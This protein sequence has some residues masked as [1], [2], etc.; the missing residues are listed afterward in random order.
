M[1][2]LGRKPLV[3]NPFPNPEESKEASEK[4]A[5]DSDS[6]DSEIEDDFTPDPAEI[7]GKLFYN[8][9]T[10]EAFGSFDEHFKRV[11]ECKS[12]LWTCELTMTPKLTYP[13]ALESERKAMECLKSIPISLK[14][15]MLFAVAQ[16]KRQ[17]LVDL[18]EDIYNFVKDRYFVGEEVEALVNGQWSNCSILNVV[19]PTE[20]ELSKKRNLINNVD[21]DSHEA[22]PPA[23]V[24]K[25]HV[26]E[27][28]EDDGNSKRKSKSKSPKNVILNADKIRRPR[29]IFTRFKNKLYVKLVTT[30]TSEKNLVLKEAALAKHGVRDGNFVDVFCQP[31]PVF[32][33]GISEKMQAEDL[34]S[35]CPSAEGKKNLMSNFEGSGD[36]RKFMAIAKLKEVKK[37]PKSSPKKETAE[38]KRKRLEREAEERLEAE[39]KRKE[40]EKLRKKEEKRLYAELL[41]DWHKPKEDL[42]LEDLKDL[43]VS[44]PVISRLPNKLFGGVMEILEFFNVFNKTL[45]FGRW[46]P[47]GLT[48]EKVEDAL[49]EE[50]MRAGLSELLIALLELIFQLQDD[51]DS[52]MGS[53]HLKADASLRELLVVDDV[54]NPMAKAVELA[55]VSASWCKQYLGVTLEDL[56]RDCC[57]IS[58]VLR[59]HLL[60]SGAQCSEKSKAWRYQQRGGYSS[61]DDPG[62]QFRLEHGDIL[63]KLSSSHVYQLSPEEKLSV[64]S[65]LIS[66]IMTYV[67]FRDA[68]DETSD[69]IISK[70]RE[71]YKIR[72]DDKKKAKEEAAQRIKEKKEAKKEGK[73]VC[74]TK[75][76]EEE[77]ENP[78]RLET[79]R[80]TEES[81]KKENSERREK[82]LIAALTVLQSQY[83]LLPMGRDRAHRNFW[84]FNSVPGIFVEDHGELIGPCQ[85][86][87]TPFPIKGLPE[88]GVKEKREDIR[89][90]LTLHKAASEVNGRISETG[91]DKENDEDLERERNIVRKPNS[92]GDVLGQSNNSAY[93]KAVVKLEACAE[94]ESKLL[95]VHAALEKSRVF[96]MCLGKSREADCPVH[97]STIERTRWSFY[98]TPEEVEALIEGLNPRG[99]REKELKEVLIAE[100]KRHMARLDRFPLHLLDITADKPGQSA[101]IEQRQKSERRKG[102]TGVFLSYATH[103][104][105]TSSEYM[106]ELTF[107]DKLLEVEEK[108]H[109]GNLGLLK[110]G[111]RDAWRDA[112]MSG[113]YDQQCAK[114][115]WAGGQFKETEVAATPR[116]PGKEESLN[117]EEVEQKE[118]RLKTRQLAAA[119]LQLE[120]S[121]EPKY[122]QPPLGESAA[123][124]SKKAGNEAENHEDEEET[125][126][127]D[128]K[129]ETKLTLLQRWELSLKNVVSVPQL[130]LHLEVLSTSIMWSR[131]TLNARCKVCR[132][133]GDEQLLL[134]C[135]GCNIGY[136]TTCLKPKLKSIPRG[137]WFCPLCKPVQPEAP[138]AR[139]P[140]RRRAF[141]E[142]SDSEIE[143]SEEDEEEENEEM[144]VEAE[145]ETSKDDDEDEGEEAV[146]A[147]EDERIDSEEDVESD[148]E[149]DTCEVCGD[150]GKLIACSG[151]KCDVQ[152]HQK[153][154]DPPVKKGQQGKWTCAKCT[155]SAKISIG[156]KSADKSFEM[157]KRDSR[158]GVKRSRS[159][160]STP[161][162]SPKRVT[163]PKRANVHQSSDS[164]FDEDEDDF[165]PARRSSSGTATRRSDHK[166]RED[167][168]LDVAM[169]SNLL[170]ELVQAEDSWPF[171][172]PVTKKDAP[173]YADKIKNPMDFGTLKGKLINNRYK[174][175][176]EFL[177]DVQLIFENCKDYNEETESVYKCAERMVKLFHKKLDKIG[178][179]YFYSDGPVVRK[180]GKSK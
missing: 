92:A 129:T 20:A 26:Q 81:R 48:F 131:S 14:R 84:T 89:K 33:H 82:D 87:P 117:P 111:E 132:R 155:K 16:T 158:R 126:D 139:R 56:T 161:E 74:Q 136:H 3:R 173:D 11:V 147:E 168:D 67:G 32:H 77:E 70:R 63:Q 140:P 51:E 69:S 130:F 118:R 88:P 7:D 31:M 144:T 114:L 71:L 175:N 45:N 22:W 73:P 135:D 93:A 47:S 134:L 101:R 85:N 9:M 83:A 171:L 165:A 1:P 52:E 96:G 151:K 157:A 102:S 8:S 105:G 80:Q 15:G 59:L 44:K 176:E 17:R 109:L 95:D 54:E 162:P 159:S 40:E 133:K 124:K 86:K 98:S 23:N 103:P 72:M 53:G 152:V 179:T 121:V 97:S 146:V 180:K 94:A 6:G 115:I 164:E 153:C 49:A 4:V 27:K 112:L 156:G 128:K 91:S 66:Q 177:N 37:S 122:M 12:L 167:V 5:A 35:A 169:M 76:D 24:Y 116:K 107:R 10:K 57:S 150:E 30:S 41:R 137:D 149:N 160:S 34:M 79:R 106:M 141:S 148:E 145:A 125:G 166:L 62:I 100:K 113:N 110:V 13:E 38:Q 18:W 127:E 64:I 39:K 90:F 36:I 174:T 170:Q 19:S 123:A 119:L 42:E 108:V 78:R 172:R 60:A 65:C 50:D 120:Q 58:E 99:L 75:M 142:T 43:P 46:F 2:L 29:G 154:A 25:Y 68:I 138:Q 28:A 104:F 55:T 163:R 61:K 178:L 143:Q 21:G